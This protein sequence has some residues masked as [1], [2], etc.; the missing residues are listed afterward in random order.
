MD[1]KPD[2]PRSGRHQRA[3][4]AYAKAQERLAAAERRSFWAKTG[5]GALIAL[6]L[7]GL[8]AVLT[9][10]STAPDH[11]AFV[12]ASRAYYDTVSPV[13]ERAIK[14]DVELH[15]QS[16]ANRLKLNRDYGEALKA[17]EDRIE[18]RK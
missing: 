15:E 7:V 13:Y 1:E 11:A 6:A 16:K 8:A 14:A 9:G 10:C 5:I 17:T 4:E 12:E 3:L 18:K 2:M